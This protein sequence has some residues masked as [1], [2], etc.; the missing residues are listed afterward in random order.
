MSSPRINKR[1]NRLDEFEGCVAGN[2]LSS[3]EELKELAKKSWDIK[4]LKKRSKFFKAFADETDL[5]S[6]GF[7]ALERCA[8]AK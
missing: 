7:S 8:Y 2:T 5:E 4:T 1:L 6:Y 3:I